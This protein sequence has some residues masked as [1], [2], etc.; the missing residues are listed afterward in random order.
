MFFKK[1]FGDQEKL[2]IKTHLKKSNSEKIMK[3]LKTLILLYVCIVSTNT[4]YAKPGDSYTGSDNTYTGGV[5]SNYDKG[6]LD[7]VVYTV[8]KKGRVTGKEVID[9]HDSL[10]DAWKTSDKAAHDK[11]NTELKGAKKENNK[12][13]SKEYHGPF[14]T[15]ARDV[16]A[17][18]NAI[19]KL[20]SKSKKEEKSFMAD[21]NGEGDLRGKGL[22]SS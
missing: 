18:G 20:F 22:P 12:K 21:K 19:R 14:S 6:T 17:I 4:I 16:K 7:S 2:V 10:S 11:A 15:V 9:S 8:D 3:L 1:V 13:N 5:E